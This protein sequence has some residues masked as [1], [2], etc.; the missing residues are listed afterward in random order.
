MSNFFGMI[1]NYED[2]KVG[3]WQKGDVFVSTAAVNDS[4]FPYETAI[5]HPDYNNGK[6]IIVEN[7]SS[8]KDAKTGFKKWVKKMSAKK[9]PATITDVGGAEINQVLIS[10]QG[11]YS[12]F[13][14]KTKRPS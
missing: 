9:H 5:A 2:R 14:K 8:L 10:L 12:T 1:E 6:L 4:S 3:R 13:K 7:H 11:G